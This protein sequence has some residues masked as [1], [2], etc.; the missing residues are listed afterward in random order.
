[1]KP[2]LSSRGWTGGSANVFTTW[3]WI[4]SEDQVTSAIDHHVP[5]MS[6][7]AATVRSTSTLT[8]DTEYSHM[9]YLTVVTRAVDYLKAPTWLVPTATRTPA[10][11]SSVPIPLAILR[12]V[13]SE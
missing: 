4:R 11:I 5:A 12:L 9:V 10:I 3:A 13:C 6:T 8:I 2:P 1:M 7:H